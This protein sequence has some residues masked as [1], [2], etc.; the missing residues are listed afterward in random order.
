MSSED[1]YLEILIK[2]E[3][4]LDDIEGKLEYI[5]NSSRNMDNH[6]S[7]VENI[8]GIVK[9]PFFY[10]LNKIQHIENTEMKRLVYI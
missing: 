2:I 10:I 3:K 7:F 4:R 1:K 5:S 9:K 6:I 8:Y